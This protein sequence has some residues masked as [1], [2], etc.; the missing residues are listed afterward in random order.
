MQQTIQFGQV[1]PTILSRVEGIVKNWKEFLCKI[2]MVSS[3]CL[4]ARNETY[5]ALC[6]EE[7]THGEVI[8]V[9]VAIVAMFLM[10]ALLNALATWM[11]GGAL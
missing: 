7:F 2:G 8:N 10:G 1:Q 11:E 6:G 9:H 3:D 4:R 5:S